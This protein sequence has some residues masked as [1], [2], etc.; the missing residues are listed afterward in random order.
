M[1]SVRRYRSSRR[2]GRKSLGRAGKRSMRRAGRRAGRRSMR[3]SMRRAGRRTRRR[4]MRGGSTSDTND[5]LRGIISGVCAKISNIPK[6]ENLSDE[7]EEKTQV[8]DTAVSEINK[9][10]NPSTSTK[11]EDEE[12]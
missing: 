5:N 1:R 7:E 6:K 11:Q 12:E 4:S 10:L 3:K 2:A 9:Q 8:I